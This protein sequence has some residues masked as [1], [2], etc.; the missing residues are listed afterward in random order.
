M[1]K[2]N[3]LILSSLLVL[4]ACDDSPEPQTPSAA[5]NAPAAAPAPAVAVYEATL[6]QGID[7]RKDGYPAFIAQVSGMSALEPWGRWSDA[8]AGGPVVRFK[9]K[10]KLPASF[11][12]VLQANAF[13]PNEGKAVKVKA[14]QVS[15]DWVI[16][17]AD[18]AGTYT[19]KFA[20]VDSDTIEFTIPSPTSPKSQG[21]ND[22]PR[23]L[24]VGFISLK[25]Q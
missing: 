9:F 22:D 25:V 1:K 7:F 15:Q 13:G 11:V 24:G 14:G 2:F 12:L 23:V 21:V 17:N 20:N 19:L 6:A 8:D 4:S 18:P 10:D 5:T 16:K 3:A